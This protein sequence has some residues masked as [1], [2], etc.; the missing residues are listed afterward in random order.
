MLT[1]VL[2]GERLEVFERRASWA[3]VQLATDGYVGYLPEAAIESPGG[4]PTHRVTA[5][6]THSRPAADLKSQPHLPLYLNSRLRVVENDGKWSRLDDGNFVFGRHLAPVGE[7]AGDPATVAEGFLGVPYVWGGKTHAGL[8]CSGLVQLAL[9]AAG[10]ACPRDTDL[11]ETTLGSPLPARAAPRRNDLVFWRGHVGIML[12][13]GR[14]LHANGHYMATVVEPLAEAA[15]RIAS[16]GP[17]TSIRR[18]L[19]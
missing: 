7:K 11:M 18:F 19:D 10:H 2:R 15:A 12:D 9:T 8:D 1:E 5:P 4:A 6:L 3:W 17:V 14:L 16:H 13:A